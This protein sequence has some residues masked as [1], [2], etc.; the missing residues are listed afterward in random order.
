MRGSS[1]ATEPLTTT[2]TSNDEVVP[3]AKKRCLERAPPL[4]IDEEHTVAAL[5]ASKQAAAEAKLAKQ[6]REM[7]QLVCRDDK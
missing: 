3:P 7:A 5:Q 4:T 6:N 2:E 1:S